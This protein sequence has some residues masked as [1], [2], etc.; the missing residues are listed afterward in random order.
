VPYVTTAS[1]TGSISHWLLHF[2]G[3]LAY[4]LIGALVFAEAALLVGFVLPGETA[5]VVGGGPGRSGIGESPGNDDRGGA[6]SHP[7]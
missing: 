1:I 7:R 6:L 5:A 3:G 4:V 2:H